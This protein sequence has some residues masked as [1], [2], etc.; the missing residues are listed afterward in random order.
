M[1]P[2]TT[3]DISINTVVKLILAV[4]SLVVLYL[5]RDIIL[6]VLVALILAIAFDRP[7]DALCGRGV[8]RF[9]ATTLIY[10][11]LF[12]VIGI[13][14]Y[15]VFPILAEQIKNFVTNYSFYLESIGRLK[16]GAN[17]I[18]FKSIFDQLSNSLTES[19]GAVMGTLITFFGG[20]ISFF[21]IIVAAIFF[22]IQENGVKKFIFYLTPIEHQPYVLNLF[23]KIQRKVGNWLWGKVG[24]AIGVGVLTS[25]GL[26]LLG[27]K[28]ALLLGSLTMILNFIPFVGAIIAA[29]PA[30]LLALTQSLALALLVVF[31]FMFINGFL[32]PFIL[33]PLFM[34]KAVDLNPA[35]ILLVV[36]VGGKLAGI[37]G[38]VFAIPVAAIAAVLIEDYI[39]RKTKLSGA[40]ID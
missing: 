31:L 25:L 14:F 36:L 20:L 22:N 19:A 6:M 7:I 33:V 26:Y 9:L 15:L 21:T 12:S 27:I 2:R 16:F 4:L 34:K 18:D 3:F 28:Y 17:L 35:L 11:L 10:L 23:D 1:E 37:L 13:L 38:V 24:V 29:V 8:P 30:V 32:E 39:Q 40:E 5:L